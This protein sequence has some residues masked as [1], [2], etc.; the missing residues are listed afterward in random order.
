MFSDRLKELRK[1]HGLTQEQLASIIGVERSSIGKY[2]GKS[3]II[4]SNDVLNALAD[5]FNVSLDYL[6]DRSIVGSG[7]STN[8]DADIWEL[9]EQLRRQPG[10]RYLFSAAKGVTEADLKKAVKI[11]EALKGDTDAD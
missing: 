4:P 6:L 10:M 8:E 5:Y 2:E 3:R 1:K 9:R 11:I 7:S